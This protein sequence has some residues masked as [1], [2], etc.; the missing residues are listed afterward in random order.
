MT[1][2]KQIALFYI[3]GFRS[4]T[5]G[6]TLWA[7]IMIKLVVMFLILKVFFFPDLLSGMTPE[8]KA[9]TISNELIMR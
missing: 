8:Q 9:E 3:E 2:L 6:R 7:L 4:M 5:L 1:T